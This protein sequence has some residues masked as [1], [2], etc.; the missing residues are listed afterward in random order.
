MNKFSI[1]YP[2]KPFSL[3]QG[4]GAN[5]DYYSKFKDSD[6]NPYKGHDGNDLFAIHGT[7]IYAAHDG[8][9]SFATDSHGG[10]GMTIRCVVLHDYPTNTG[11]GYFSTMYW[12]MIGNT[13]PQ[14]KSPIP[15]DGKEY[16]VKMGD[17]IGYADNT[18]APYES[19]GTHL[20]FGLFVLDESGSNP[21]IH[22]GFN[23]RI[24][25]NL[26][27]NGIFAQDEVAWYNKMTALVSL[28]QKLVDYYKS[29]KNK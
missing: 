15:L 11:N 4:F 12:H 13:D 24:D 1:C 29:L 17:L 9:I 2:V 18:G 3:N 8:M 19:T 7:P 26:Y 27:Y 28:L 20:H 22:N 23:G 25:P 5:P 10:E 21:N 6:G 16:P 14:Y